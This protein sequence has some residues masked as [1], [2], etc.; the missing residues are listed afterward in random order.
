[1]KKEEIEV[2]DVEQKVGAV[3]PIP[4]DEREAGKQRL[5]A[6]AKAKLRKNERRKRRI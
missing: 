4:K 3:T 1:V 6:K 2:G 5:L